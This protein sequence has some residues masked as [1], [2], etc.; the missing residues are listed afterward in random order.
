MLVSRAALGPAEPKMLHPFFIVRVDR[1][2]ALIV[3]A[4]QYYLL[5]RIRW[6]AAAFF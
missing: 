2:S 1:A 5:Q 6:F 4:A 3:L